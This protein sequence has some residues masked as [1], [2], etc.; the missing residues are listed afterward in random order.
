M[1]KRDPDPDLS[2]ARQQRSAGIA[3]AAAAV[4]WM[5]LQFVGAQGVI[6]TRVMILF[7]LAALAVMVWALV[8]TFRIWRRRRAARTR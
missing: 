7:D 1:T 3:I 6:S 8:V 5:A 2:L 4:V